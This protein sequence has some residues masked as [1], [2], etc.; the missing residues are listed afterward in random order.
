MYKLFKHKEPVLVQNKRV[1]EVSAYA[2]T[3]LRAGSK[4]DGIGGF[5][6]YGL[7]EKPSGL[8]IGLSEKAVLTKAKKKNEPIEWGDVEFPEY[9]SALKLWEEQERKEKNRA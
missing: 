8:P 3:N 4:L 6:L 5:N 7:L 2:K 9:D 1:L